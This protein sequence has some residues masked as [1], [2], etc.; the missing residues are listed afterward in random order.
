MFTG[1]RPVGEPQPS[2]HDRGL[3]H[4]R[5]ADDLRARRQRLRRRR[6]HPVAARRPAD[7]IRHGARTSTRSPP[8]CRTRAAWSSCRRSPGSARRTGTRPRAARSSASRAARQRP[9][10]PAPRSRA[11]RSRSPTSSSAMEADTGTRLREL[12]VDGGAAASDL[13]M[14]IQAD[15]LGVRVA[16]PAN[17][18]TT[19][20]GAAFMAGLAVGVWPDLAALA[21]TWRVER[22]FTAADAAPESR[23]AARALACGPSTRARGSWDARMNRDE[24]LRR[25]RRGRRVGRH[26][27]RRRRDRARRRGRRRDARL[28]HP[29]ARAGRLRHSDLEPQHEARARRRAL[30]RAGQPRARHGG[31]AR[32]RPAARQRAARR[33]A[34]CPSSCRATNGGR[35]RSTASA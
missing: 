14:Q 25:A 34:T 20:L 8:R 31:A 3:A 4:R 10:S 9:T 32:A 26:R 19:A 28:S 29:A 35:G 23:A 21:K 7:L 18:E 22:T 1:T 16:R 27:H 13:L 24:M 5:R 15:L 6:R 17:L 2:A 11:S 30:P 33:R 12:R